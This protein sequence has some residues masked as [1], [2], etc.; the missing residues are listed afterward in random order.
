KPLTLAVPTSVDAVNKKSVPRGALVPITPMPVYAQ[1]ETPELKAQLG[2][3]GV[4]PLPKR[5]MI[6]KLR[7]IHQYTHQVVSSG[8]EDEATTRSHAPPR[9]PPLG[10]GR[11][12][13]STREQRHPETGS[14]SLA[15]SQASHSDESSSS[16]RSNP[17]ALELSEDDDDAEAVPPSQAAAREAEKMAAVK[18]FILSNPDLH[19]RVLLYEPLVLS[20][21]QAH[22]KEAGVR[23]GAAKLLDFLDS[24]CITFTTAKPH[25]R[26]QGAKKSKGPV[27][28]KG[29]RLVS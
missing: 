1:M 14:E 16:Q 12:P 23:L 15:P 18:K 27:P 5:Q 26:Q 4:R 7:E 20:Q 24:H 13:T 29:G 28:K 3:F 25:R 21:L 19:R 2:R 9:P 8:S 22:L 10:E 11:R 17:E 6:L